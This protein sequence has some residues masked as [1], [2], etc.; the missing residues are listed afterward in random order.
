MAEVYLPFRAPRFRWH[1]K[2]A[3]FNPAVDGVRVHDDGRLV[4]TMGRRLLA[5]EVG[6]IAGLEPV[7]LRSMVASI[8]VRRTPLSADLVM[9]TDLGP[10]LRL[11]FKE[12][13]VPAIGHRRHRSVTVTLEDP[14]DLLPAIIDAQRGLGL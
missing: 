5:T 10:A 4:A 1:L 7:D 12:P 14:H 13:V 6:N 8:G 9:A 3:R 2:Y 11:G